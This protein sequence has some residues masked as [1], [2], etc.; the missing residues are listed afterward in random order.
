MP[1]LDLKVGDYVKGEDWFVNKGGYIEPGKVYKVLAINEDGHFELNSGGWWTNG[2]NCFVRALPCP[3]CNM[4][5]CACDDD[6][7]LDNKPIR[8]YAK[9]FPAS[10]FN[11]WPSLHSK[12]EIAKHLNELKDE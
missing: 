12:M 6:E 1:K 11:T 5:P 4:D 3:I 8:P 2:S 9:P 7:E 10:A